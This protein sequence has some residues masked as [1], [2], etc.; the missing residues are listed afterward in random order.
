MEPNSAAYRKDSCKS[1][2]AFLNGSQ[3]FCV[4]ARP[5]QIPLEEEVERASSA[6]DRSVCDIPLPLVVARAFRNH[7]VD[8]TGCWH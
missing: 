6:G 2:G 8:G 7:D 4:F 1:S 3:L 5:C